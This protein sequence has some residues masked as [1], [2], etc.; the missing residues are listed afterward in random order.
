MIA[1]WNSS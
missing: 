1:E